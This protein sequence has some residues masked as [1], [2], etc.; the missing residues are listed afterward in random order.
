MN[1]RFVGF[2]FL[3]CLLFL[4]PILAQDAQVT[5]ATEK[6]RMD[7]L[8]TPINSQPISIDEVLWKRMKMIGRPARNAILFI[9]DGLS[10]SCIKLA[11]DTIVGRSGKLEM[12]R[13]PV[14]ARV[15]TYAVDC[16]VNDSAA[17]ASSLATGK[18]GQLRK[19]SMDASGKP[20]KTLLEMA[21]AK[22]LRTG[23]ITDT[24]VT[25][26]TPAAFASHTNDRDDET[27]IARQMLAIAPDLIMGGGRSYFLP[28]EKG[29][30]QSNGV[31]LLMEAE[32]RG[33]RVLEN[34]KDLVSAVGS[35][36][37]KVLGLFSKSFMPYSFEPESKRIPDLPEMTAAGLNLLETDKNGFFLMVES[38]QIDATLHA[39][40]AA[41][42][43]EQLREM[44]RTVR[45]L[46]D[47]VKSHPDTILVM[48]PDH[49]TGDMAVLETFDEA[50]FHRTAI[51][52]IMLSR[53]WAEKSS[54]L[55]TGLRLTF[56]RLNFPTDELASLG[57]A[58]NTPI[59]EM[60]LGDA[61]FNKLG[62]SFMDPHLQ[63]RLSRTHGHT[64]EDLFLHAV[65][66]HQS[67]FSGTMTLPEVSQRL[68]ATLNL[69]ESR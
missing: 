7:D 47:F 34:R 1:T 67:L 65:G 23:L 12:D 8:I 45:V 25:H 55:N 29:G 43:V 19:L 10:A 6:N 24:R 27:D 44:D 33:Y 49:P 9:A 52:T 64:G 58:R 32:R 20:L 16:P 14:T 53:R 63:D 50:T 48:V 3:L 38:G 68:A 39:H 57:K 51:S 31:N 42:L 4:A 2:A 26:A 35:Q 18:D 46:Q 21:K 13:F 40:D 30:K 36:A 54:D 15:I 5:P 60:I 22:G 59:F 62:I 37:P 28:S 69:G 17:A 56:P 41:E 11:R 66:L 61:V